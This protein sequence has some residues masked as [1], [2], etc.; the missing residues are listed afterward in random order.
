[1]E[2]A[3][4]DSKVQA[5]LYEKEWDWM[6]R[7]DINQVVKHKNYRTIKNKDIESMHER[8]DDEIDG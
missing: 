4:D 7:D 1:L 2:E 5:S 3:T 8:S 6:N